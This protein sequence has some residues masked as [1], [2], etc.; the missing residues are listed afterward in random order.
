MLIIDKLLINFHSSKIRLLWWISAE[1]I[2]LMISYYCLKTIIN[3]ILFY[4]GIKPR[5]IHKHTIGNLLANTL[6]LGEQQI[7]S[8]KSYDVLEH[9][10]I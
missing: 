1:H 6:Q 10:K 8:L 7:Y 5:E 2:N 9:L 3:Q 4:F